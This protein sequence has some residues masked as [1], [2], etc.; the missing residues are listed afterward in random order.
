MAYLEQLRSRFDLED[1]LAE[2]GVRPAGQLTRGEKAYDE[3]EFEKLAL[4]GASC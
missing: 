1:E 3:C 2:V 4:A